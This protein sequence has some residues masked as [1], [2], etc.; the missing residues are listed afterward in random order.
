MALY[1]FEREKHVEMRISCSGTTPTN[2][3]ELWIVVCGSILFLAAVVFSV[4]ARTPVNTL[5]PSANLGRSR[6]TGGF[7]VGSGHNLGGQV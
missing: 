3:R 4:T 2:T 5:A 1:I 6:R 7:L